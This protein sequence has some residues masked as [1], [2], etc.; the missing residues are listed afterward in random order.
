TPRILPRGAACASAAAAPPAAARSHGLDPAPQDLT[1][2][3]RLIL[4]PASAFETGQ[5]AFA[6]SAISR[7]LAA[8]APGASTEQVSALSV[9]AKPPPC[10][11]NI[12]T[13]ALVS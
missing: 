6:P 1:F 12:S 13:T 2:S 11:G 8:S 5:F 10:A 9:I 3:S 4:M 7:T